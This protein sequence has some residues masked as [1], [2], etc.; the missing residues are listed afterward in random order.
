MFRNYLAAALRNLARNRLYAAINVIGLSIGFATA[1]LVG[2]FVRHEMTF[3]HFIPGYQNIYKLSHGLRLPGNEE[4][5]TE[6]LGTWMPMQMKLDIP[7]IEVAK[8]SSLFQPVSLRHGDVEAIE[9]RF[10]WA[11]PN[12]FDVLPLPVYAGNLKTALDRP[13]GL[14]LTRRMA[15]RYFGT[16]NPIGETLE[17]DRARVMTVTAVLQDLPSNTHLDTEIFGSGKAVEGREGPFGENARVYVYVRLK[18]GVTADQVRGAL[19]DVID[20]YPQKRPTGKWSDIH[21]YPLVPIADIHLTSTGAFAMT[22]GADPRTIR[23]TGVVGVLVLLLASINF[24]NLKTAR[25][26]RRAVEVGVRKVC[27]AGRRDLVVQFIGESLVYATLAMLIAMALVELVLLPWLNAFLDRS[28]VF[29]YWRWP[30]LGYLVAAV[31][32]VGTL[33]GAY[34]AFV[35]SSF[36]PAAVMKGAGASVAGSGRVRQF[37]VIVQFAILIGLMLSTA[38]IYR[39]TQFGLEQGLRFDKDQLLIVDV[40]PADCEKSSF[41]TAVDSLPGVLGAA[42]SEFFLGE[43]GTAQYFAPDGRE[44][45]F[46]EGIASAGM[47][48]LMGLK[49]VAGRF[50]VR[51]READVLPPPRDRKPGVPLR[52]VVNETGAKVLGFRTAADAVGKLIKVPRADVR[53]EIIGVVPDVSGET[54]RQN[55]WPMF[56]LNTEGWNSRLNVKLRRSAVPET[57]RALDKAWSQIPGQTRPISRRFYDDYVQ[58]IYA[59]LI[60]QRTLFAGFAL[61]AL[62]LAGLGLFGLAGFT[63]ER[64]TRE[65]GVRKAMGANTGAVVR[66]LLW[67][68]AKPV[69]WAN[70]IAWPIAGYI[71]Y[72]WLLGF[73]YRIDLEPWVFV[74][75]SLVALV[76]AMVTVSTHSVLVARANAVAAL[77]YE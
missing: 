46:K 2:L 35:L 13:D 36:R 9:K 61:V 23:A 42:C 45:T 57:L 40:P 62:L 34:P 18:P 38:I 51:N 54:V 44:V 47:F 39:Q 59:S 55:I 21:Y 11:D 50:F 8:L 68:F 49:P 41:R 4:L 5:P 10:H 27:G 76:I 58:S 22:P 63:V 26:A 69:L 37:L 3:D 56:Y 32:V 14:V 65:I 6:D 12:I 48:E 29:G 25:A 28:I 20:R 19:V 64:R 71:M 33:A 43:F 17:I 70:V 24:V 66:L 74:A 30:M 67:Q 73:A 31:L 60:R 7:Q 72:R 75:S 15:R 53:Y 16:D 1:L 77:R 52:A